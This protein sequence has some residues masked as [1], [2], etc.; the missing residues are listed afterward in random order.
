MSKQRVSNKRNDSAS[1]A[2]R[3]LSK[4]RL[5][6]SIDMPLLIVVILLLATGLV[7]V[8]SASAPSS[9]A[10]YGNSFETGYCSINWID[11]Y[12]LFIKI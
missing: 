10:D 12:V 6:N 8:L 3:R 9:L 1:Q 4:L 2:S 7:M 11:S 5:T